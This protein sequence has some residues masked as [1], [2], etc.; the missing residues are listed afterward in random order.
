[1]E[2]EWIDEL[3]F[4]ELELLSLFVIEETD[5]MEEKLGSSWNGMPLVGWHYFSNEEM[6]EML[7]SLWDLWSKVIE[8]CSTWR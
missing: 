4:S 3:D 5:G 7:D 1:M 2:D 6:D 8:T